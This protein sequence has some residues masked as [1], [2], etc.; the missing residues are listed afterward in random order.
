MLEDTQSHLLKH[1]L[2]GNHQLIDLSNMKMIDSSFHSKKF[3]QKI[4]EALYIKQYGPSLKS[5]E[6]SVELKLFN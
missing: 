1:A 6:Q 4:S 5:Q 2:L 3:K